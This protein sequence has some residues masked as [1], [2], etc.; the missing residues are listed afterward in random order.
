MAIDKEITT[1]CI[2]EKAGR[3][4]AK[5]NN[6]QVTG[7]VGILIKAKNSGYI[8]S[9]R[10]AIENMKSRGIYLS[11]TVINFALEMTEEKS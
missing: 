4:I 9:I 2:D 1:V 8:S 5:L 11:E 7:S 10:K 6:L 3:R